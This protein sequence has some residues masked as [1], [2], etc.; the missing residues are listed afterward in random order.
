MPHMKPPPQRGQHAGTK[1]DDKAG[2]S[3]TPED[4]RILPFLGLVTPLA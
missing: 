2:E 4:H 3:G 1:A